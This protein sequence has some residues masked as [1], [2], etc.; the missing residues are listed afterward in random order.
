MKSLLTVEPS[1]LR[2][3]REIAGNPVLLA[4]AKAALPAIRDNATAPAGPAGVAKVLS[5]LFVTYLQPQRS[6]AEWA[7][8]WADY[9][10]V[11]AGCSL[12]SLEAA[13]GACLHNGKFEFLPKPGKFLELAR[14]TENRAVR[15]YDRARQAVEFQEPV[16][17]E[18]IS[19]EQMA[20]VLAPIGRR[21]AEKTPAEKEAVRAAMRRFIEQDDARRDR[22]KAALRISGPDV[23]APQVENGITPQMR[24][25]LGRDHDNVTT[26]P[27]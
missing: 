9:N 8:F 2:A 1:N 3:V 11:L 21:P 20:E 14:M 13:K 23:K 22:E 17:R 26:Q 16:T 19:A 24:A 4:E 6:E 27:S 10:T 12:S 7:T 25:L 5:S 18:T 15:A